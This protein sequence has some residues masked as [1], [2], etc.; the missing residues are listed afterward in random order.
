[1]KNF[2][3][4]MKSISKHPFF[5]FIIVGILLMLIPLLS[6][7]LSITFIDAFV[8]TLIYF[9]VALG[10]S[11]LLGYAGLASLGTSAFI[12][13]GTFAMYTGMTYL[14]LGFALTLLLSLAVSIALGLLFGIV[15]LRIE[16][17]YLAI[18]TLGLSEILVEV[19]KNLDK[20]TGGVSGINLK[21]FTI[22][23]Y[24]LSGKEVFIFLIVVVVIAMMATYNIMQSGTGRAMLSIK[25]NQSAAQAMGISII[26]YRLMAF[27][28]AT[29]YATIAGMFYMGYVKFSM[30]SQWS[31]ALSLNILAAVVVGGVKSIYGIFLGTFVIFGLDLLVFKT[32]LGQTQFANMSFVIS[33]VLII[34]VI[35]FYPDG[36]IGLIKTTHYKIKNRK[37]LKGEKL[38]EEN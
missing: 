37:K 24:S 11:I 15:S 33:G 19:F 14:G 35:M 28:I 12:A 27:I 13:I 30:A 3:T 38:N 22:F 21:A 8:T 10:F 31:L 16:G 9:I 29:I 25:N 26:K 18:V 34:V 17:M 5:G 2:M 23:G 1:M 20:F 4:R 36:L 6:N 32:L 7:F